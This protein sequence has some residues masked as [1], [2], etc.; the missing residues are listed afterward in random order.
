MD[1]NPDSFP[2][3]KQPGQ[4]GREHLMDPLPEVIREDYKGSEKLLDHVALITG[5]DSG[6]GRSVAVHFAREGADVAIVYLE[7]DDDAQETKNMIIREGRECLLLKGDV[8]DEKFCQKALEKTVEKFNRLDIL[9]NNAAIQYPQSKVE[10]VSPEQF[11]KTFEVNIYHYFYF[12]REAVKYMKEGSTI[13]NTTSVNAFTGNDHLLDYSSTKG[14]I[15][16]FTFSLAKQLAKKGIRVNAVAPGPIWTPLIP[17]T[18]EVEDFGKQSL[19]GRAGQPS[20]IGPAFVF[21]ASKDSSY[22]L[23][24]TMHINGGQFVGT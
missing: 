21:L 14:A 9:V 10:D 22:M 4:P 23:G 18:L 19:L 1:K 15:M 17:A 5:G 6:I 24:Q 8:V 12:S 13:I 2:K 11:K 20:E 16:S 7:E 3:Q